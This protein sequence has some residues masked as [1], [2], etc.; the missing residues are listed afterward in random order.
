MTV[1]PAS[2][3]LTQA[4]NRLLDPLAKLSNSKTP[5][6]PFQRIVLAFETVEAKSLLDSGPQ[7]SPI[8]PEGMPSASVAAPTCATQKS[9]CHR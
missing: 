9:Q 6:G 7:S 5:A 4:S 3:A 2:F 1:A 8:Q